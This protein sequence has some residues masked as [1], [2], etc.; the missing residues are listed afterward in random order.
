ML[1]GCF[2]YNTHSIF[3]GKR[4]LLETSLRASQPDTP[5]IF[6]SK[7]VLFSLSSSLSVPTPVLFLSARTTTATITTTITDNGQ[8]TT[9]Q[10]AT[11]CSGYGL[12]LADFFDSTKCFCI[13][14]CAVSHLRLCCFPKALFCALVTGWTSI[15]LSLIVACP[16]MVFLGGFIWLYLAHPGGLLCHEQQLKQAQRGKEKEAC[17]VLGAH[18]F[19]QHPFNYPPQRSPFLDPSTY[20]DSLD[21]RISKTLPAGRDWTWCTRRPAGLVGE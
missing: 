4:G 16:R 19:T 7:S 13:F 3:I 8:R 20:S 5:W 18:N 2:E 10:T 15:F 6:A 14:P 9:R 1:V 21:Y 11:W 17:M 12:S